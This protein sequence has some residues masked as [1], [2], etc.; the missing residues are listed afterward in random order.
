M[1]KTWENVLDKTQEKLLL[2]DLS[3]CKMIKIVQEVAE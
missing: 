2:S 3:E 1:E